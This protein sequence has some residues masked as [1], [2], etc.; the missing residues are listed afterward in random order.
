MALC[1]LGW[2]GADYPSANAVP[3][4]RGSR[5]LIFVGAL[6]MVERIGNLSRADYVLQA[7]LFIKFTW[8]SHCWFV[9][10]EIRRRNRR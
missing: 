4:A 8:P 5:P 6:W 7:L 1:R 3:C 10:T 2:D 9:R